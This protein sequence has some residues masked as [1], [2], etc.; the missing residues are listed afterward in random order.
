MAYST[1][2][3]PSLLGDRIGGGGAVWN[4]TSTDAATDVAAAGYFSN[5]EALGMK[6]GDQVNVSVREEGA[7]TATMSICYVS[8]ITDAGAATVVAAAAA[9]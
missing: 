5:G 1:S 9:A 7:D 8:A 6:A 4:Y 3:P 2:N